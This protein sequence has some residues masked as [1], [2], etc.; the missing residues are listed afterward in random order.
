MG[1]KVGCAVRGVLLAGL[2]VSGSAWA[3]EPVKLV[4]GFEWQEM[5]AGLGRWDYLGRPHLQRPKAGWRGKRLESLDQVGPDGFAVIDGTPSSSRHYPRITCVPRF[6]TQGRFAFLFQPEMREMGSW[7]ALVRALKVKY[8]PPWPVKEPGYD[9]QDHWFQRMAQVYVRTWRQTTDWS[10]Y[11]RLRFD[12]TSVGQPVVLGVRVRDGSGPRIPPGPTGLRTAVGLFTVPADQTVTCD[13]PLAEMA[14]VAEMD[15]GKVHRLNIRL[16]GLPSGKPPKE[17]LLD[18]I[19]LVAGGGEPKPALKLVAM[20]DPVRPFARCVYVRPPTR[21]DPQKL[22]RR[23]GPVEPLGP[24]VVNRTAL[25]GGRLGHGWGHFGGSGATYFSNSRRAVVAYDNDRLLV[26]IGGATKARGGR[27]GTIALASFDGGRTW[28]GIRPGQKDF[29]ILPWHLRS[30]FSADRFG[31]VY[32]V[33]TPNCDSYKEGQDICLHRLAFTGGGWVDD[34]FAVLHQDGYKCPHDCRALQLATGRIW[35]A[36]GDGFG[37]YLA[38]CSDDDGFTWMP[39]KDASLP[40]P[41][42]F[43]RPQLASATGGDDYRPPREILLWPTPAVCGSLLVPYKGQVAVFSLD[44]SRWAV[45]DGRKWLPARKGIKLGR[46][47]TVTVLGADHFFLARGA[48]YDNRGREKL[49]GLVVAD[50][51]EGKWNR[52]VLEEADVAGAIVTASG[53]AVFCFYVKK[54]GEDNYEVRYRRW[55]DGKW[56]PSVKIATEHRRVNHL[57]APQICPP[58]YA[59]VF[60]DQHFRKRGDASEVKFMRIPNQ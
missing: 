57:A 21:R 28:G 9:P 58:S 42:P 18:N 33:G 52:Q 16:N 56:G 60:W 54:A 41:R 35:A 46:L 32:A 50:L 26:V 44:G 55:L 3:A 53:E 38:R 20:S 7:S 12:V 2:W 25:Y 10:G 36:W 49:A 43:Y 4:A 24:V 13:F 47:L 15:L 14:R 23:L 22:R 5:K 30:N 31:N 45:H 19:R 48:P 27:G 51:S 11:E 59:A 8:P 1:H 34:R 17:L 39:C 29:T 37:G 40:P 6:A